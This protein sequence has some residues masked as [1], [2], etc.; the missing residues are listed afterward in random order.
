[1]TAAELF[2]DIVSTHCDCLD[3]D[4]K[5]PFVTSEVIRIG[6][7]LLKQEIWATAHE[8]RESL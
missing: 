7:Y 6:L 3:W 4:Y 8:K 1:L 2:R 5:L